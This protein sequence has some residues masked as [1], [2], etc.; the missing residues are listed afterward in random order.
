MD[1]KALSSKDVRINQ[2]RRRRGR[3]FK[4]NIDL[5]I[6]QVEQ[7]AGLGLNVSQMANCLSVK[8]QTLAIYIEKHPILRDAIDRGKD[9]LTN[10]LKTIAVKKAINGDSDMLK[11]VLKN[12]SDWKDKDGFGVSVQDSKVV[13]YMPEVA[14]SDD[15]FKKLVES[16]KIKVSQ[17]REIKQ[18]ENNVDNPNP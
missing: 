1:S 2:I 15:D 6:K 9:K 13:I 17:I 12:I 8:R 14:Q 16:E 7:M 10:T 3:E 4:L 18:I 5:L 11:Y